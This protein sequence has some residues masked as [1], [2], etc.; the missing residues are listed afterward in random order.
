MHGLILIDKPAGASSFDVVRRM[1]RIART[2]K[3]GHTGTLDPDAT[4]LL[5]I[6]LGHCTKL[7]NFLILDEKEYV[8]GMRLG[9]ETDTGDSTGAVV[10]TCAWEHVTEADFCEALASFR[11]EIMQVPPIYSALKVDGKRA[12]ELAR[13]GMEFELE[14]RPIVIHELEVLELNL[15]DAILR[16]RCGSGTYVRS[17]ARDI[18]QAL[19]SRAHTTSI[20]RTKV[21]PF[22]LQGAYTL[23]GLEAM[24]SD[25][26]RDSMLSPVEM[27]TTVTM[28]TGSAEEVRAL[29]Y[30]QRID[31]ALEAGLGD[32]VAVKTLNDELV[33]ITTVEAMLGD[34]VV[35]LKPVRVLMA[36]S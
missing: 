10:E 24:S 33:A 27:L 1:R 20:R 34:E 9:A 11:G 8:F 36:A 4:G 16:V 28:W 2:R 25:E 14:A 23:E 7:A 35:R 12:Y 15:P 30:G 13:K 5:P 31:V 26:V 6:V 29:G 22:D 19:G 32:V 3:V 17:L 21:G 18:G